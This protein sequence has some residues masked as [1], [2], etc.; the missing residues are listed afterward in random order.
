MEYLEWC[1]QASSS[2]DF[3]AERKVV[4]P[5]SVS[6]LE[7]I[8]EVTDRILGNFKPLDFLKSL[9]EFIKDNED[10]LVEVEGQ[11]LITA[12]VILAEIMKLVP[13]KDP[14]NMTTPD[15]LWRNAMGG[16]EKLLRHTGERLN[17]REVVN[18][19]VI[20]AVATA[21][22]K[23]GTVSEK[24]KGERAPPP[25][26]QKHFRKGHDILH[27]I[28]DI[29]C[30][31]QYYTQEHQDRVHFFSKPEPDD[32]CGIFANYALLEAGLNFQKSDNP[33][34]GWFKGGNFW[35]ELQKKDAEE[36]K[37]WT[38][39][40]TTTV[41]QSWDLLI[42][43]A[44]TKTK[45]LISK[46]D[47]YDLLK[48]GDI[49]HKKTNSHQAL[50]ICIENGKITSIDGNTSPTDGTTGG[51]I[52]VQDR[53]QDETFWGESKFFFISPPPEGTNSKNPVKE[54]NKSSLL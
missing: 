18:K 49:I 22:S 12:S 7:K 40:G 10:I 48:A 52:F 51:R 27:K 29:A 26:E 6:I 23:V 28:F 19:K 46:Q 20:L 17:K 43:K 25:N 15:D 5:L 42:R 14:K 33:P 36:L 53:S 37:L 4:E 1:R 31:P 38:V 11:I 47:N 30:H 44:D 3:I 9:E 50:C 34:K 21:I 8:K 39:G 32:W 2:H 16:Y 24:E 41:Y 13:A 35:K 45:R 54:R